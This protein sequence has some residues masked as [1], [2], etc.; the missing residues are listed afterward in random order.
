[1]EASQILSNQLY[2]SNNT[3][4]NQRNQGYPNRNTNE[5]NKIEINTNNANPLTLSFAQLETQCYWCGK[6]GHKSLQSKHPNSIPK[7]EWA[8]TKTKAQFA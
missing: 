4:I 8:I 1:M 7:N 5:N 3:K 2:E 6:K